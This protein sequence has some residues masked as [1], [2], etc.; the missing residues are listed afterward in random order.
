MTR[1]IPRPL[2]RVAALERALEHTLEQFPDASL[3]T[4]YVIDPVSSAYDVETGGLPVAEDWYEDAL[5][6]SQ[7]DSRGSRAAAGSHEVELTTIT[8]VGQPAREILEYAAEHDVDQV[9][10]GSHGRKGIGRAFLLKRRGDGDPPR[11]R[12]GDGRQA[13]CALLHEGTRSRR[14]E[15]GRVCR[16]VKRPVNRTIPSLSDVSHKTVLCTSASSFR[17][18]VANTP[19]ARQ[20]YALAPRGPSTRNCTSSPS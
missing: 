5:G 8:V 18:T 17:P 19:P 11:P 2:R 7:R 20:Q 14:R 4:I 13:S 1:R 9:V 12:S 3:T 6:A 15:T 10:M 16:A